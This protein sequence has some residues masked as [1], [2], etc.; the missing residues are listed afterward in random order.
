MSKRV[1]VRPLDDNERCSF[2]TCISCSKKHPTDHAI[3]DDEDYEW[4]KQF[5]WF[6]VH[7]TDGSRIGVEVA[8]FTTDL[9]NPCIV[10]I[11]HIGPP[12]KEIT[13]GLV[14]MANEILMRSEAN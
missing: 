13:H 5:E 4:A 8:R 2:K 3:V 10:A 12:G 1:L 9:D 6:A 11:A 14:F 7:R